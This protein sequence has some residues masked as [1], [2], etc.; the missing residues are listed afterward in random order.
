[1]KRLLIIGF[2][3]F[4][5]TF[6]VAQT[7]AQNE[8]IKDIRTMFQDAMNRIKENSEESEYT[9]NSA[10]LE[11]N[12]MYPGS[13]MQHYK[14]DMYLEDTSEDEVEVNWQPYFIR[15]KYNWGMREFVHE[16][17]VNSKNGKPIF[18]FVKMPDEDGM[19]EDRLYFNADGSLCYASQ[20]KYE[21]V[22]GKKE[23]VKAMKATDD[24]VK[25]AISQYNNVKKWVS[26]TTDL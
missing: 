21:I 16:C 1:M 25:S 18:L 23:Y 4:C 10:H 8:R 17:L 7:K 6:A 5:S 11:L 26:A 12:R 19:Y 9:D 14:I 3:A 20:T 22:E 2:L 15:F 13:G 24:S